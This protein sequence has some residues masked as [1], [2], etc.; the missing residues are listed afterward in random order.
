V[1]DTYSQAWT[2]E[3]GTWHSEKTPDAEPGNADYLVDED[4]V[5]RYAYPVGRNRPRQNV[6]HWAWFGNSLA[7]VFHCDAFDTAPHWRGAIMLAEPVPA[8]DTTRHLGRHIP[9]GRQIE[10]TRHITRPDV[11]HLCVSADATAMVCD[12]IG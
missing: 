5:T 12:T 6:S 7:K 10:L 9:G 11:C 4:G 2:D 8:D 1:S 3:A